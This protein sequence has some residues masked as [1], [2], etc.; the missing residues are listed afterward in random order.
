MKKIFCE[1]LIAVLFLNFNAACGQAPPAG[2][3]ADFSFVAIGD[4]GEKS[5]LLTDNAKTM[6]ALFRQDRFDLLIFLGDNFYPTGLNFGASGNFQ[7]EVPKKIKD[8]LDPFREVMAG[9]G[10]KN[11]HAVAGNHEYYA[12]VLLDKSFFF[13]AFSISALPVGIT[14]KGNQR[15][16]TIS[17]WTYHYSLPSEVIFAAGQDSVQFI[18]FDSAILLRTQPETWRPSLAHLQRLLAS[19][20]QR[21]RVKWRIFAAHHPLYSVGEHGGYSE[22]DPEARAVRYLNHCDPDS[23][24][25]NYFQNLVDPQD[26][27]TER[28]RAYR[29]SVHAA[30][31]RSGVTVQL[32]LSG[33]DHSLQLLHNPNRHSAFASLG[34]LAEQVC[35]RCPKIF[36]V[37]GAGA[38]TS[39]VKMPS[40]QKGE[41]TCPH[42]DPKQEG[43][44]QFGFVRVDFQGER[45]RVRFFS[46]KTKKEIDMGGRREFFIKPDGTL[47]SE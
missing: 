17:T 36:L 21:P 26:L 43:K 33:H 32:A 14:N 7:K 9:L 31:H 1:V 44:S 29:D 11:V 20:R 10:K 18:F 39:R 40:S 35:A 47:D 5:D 22:W 38:K 19:T 28:Y 24:A 4:I 2:S 37:S 27:C 12:K 25:V 42:P 6:T 45:L 3:K 30:I 8:V 13:G 46:G 16:D 15:A 34:S 23:D 41:Y